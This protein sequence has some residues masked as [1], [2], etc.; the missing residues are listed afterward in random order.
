MIITNRI[1]YFLL[2][3]LKVRHCEMYSAYVDRLSFRAMINF[4]FR[5]YKSTTLLLSFSIFLLI[6]FFFLLFIWGMFFSKYFFTDIIVCFGKIF[7][8]NTCNPTRFRFAQCFYAKN[9]CRRRRGKRF[10]SGDDLFSS[11]W[12]DTKRH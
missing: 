3:E 2:F 5:N 8:R 10:A 11:T 4:P 1:D 7:S 6:N 9:V 12:N